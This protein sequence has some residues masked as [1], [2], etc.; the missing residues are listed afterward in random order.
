ML[1]FSKLRY[2]NFLSTGDTFTEIDF[3]RSPAT[4]VTGGN[5]AGKS[6]MLDALAFALFGK[7]HRNINKPQLVNSVNQKNAMVEVEFESG[8]K[9]YMVRRGIAPA[10]F[11]IYM[12]GKLV[13]Q[14]STARDYQLF[15]EQNILK[16]NYKTF[17]Q[18]VVLGSSSFT[19]FMQLSANHR[20]QVIE[21]LLDI[22]VF[23][24]MNQILKEDSA[25]VRDETK[26]VNTQTSLL[27]GRV[28]MQT[29]H[30]AQL[31]SMS[32]DMIAEKQELIEDLTEKGKSLAGK[33]DSLQEKIDASR[34]EYQTHKKEIDSKLKVVRESL[35]TIG[36]EH[37]AA[38]KN[39]KFFQNNDTCPTCTQDISNEFKL[40]K[41]VDLDSDILNYGYQMSDLEKERDDALNLMDAL[42]NVLDAIQRDEKR[43]A[44]FN[45]EAK[46]I[47]SQIK[48]LQKEVTALQKRADDTADA[49]K[50]LDSIQRELSQYRERKSFL[51]EEMSYNSVVFEMLK[52]SGIKTK[53]IKQYLPAMNR[54]INEYLHVLDFFVLFEMDESFNETIL[55]RHRDSFSY[56][57]FSEGEKQRIDLAILF[58]WRQIAKMKN[59]VATNLLILDETFDS[60][61]DTDGIDN[62]MKILSTLDADTNVF[63]ISHKGHL[64]AEKFE[65]G[66]K[67]EKANNFSVMKEN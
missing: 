61:L 58:T 7:A 44:G 25:R 31:E 2:K 5:G 6:T 50:E 65:H 21:N 47:M 20:R 48:T 45:S 9:Q 24:Q 3:L 62:L 22:S 64:M 37:K 26:D 27:E 33:A 30:I 43:I 15:L 39:L 1:I 10:K 12:N 11:E 54:L 57:S 8:K 19:P 46:V 67:F 4:L 36:A 51:T 56:S 23:T 63:V 53:I 13:D 41:V 14:S 52:D 35:A 29:D 59:S 34:A 28:D 17:H 32:D 40:D 42:S 49:R 16:M 38:S 66:L 55:S 60:S 18:V